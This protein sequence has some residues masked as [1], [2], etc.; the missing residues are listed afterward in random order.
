MRR[1]NNE[2]VWDLGEYNYVID[3]K[4]VPKCLKN[5]YES[6]CC[7]CSFYGK[8]LPYTDKIFCEFLKF[9]QILIDYKYYEKV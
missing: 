3:R 7:L 1:F 4:L 9:P 2:P 8:C 6:S 5:N